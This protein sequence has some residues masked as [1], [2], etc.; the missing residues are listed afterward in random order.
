MKQTD[1]QFDP[2]DQARPGS[3]DQAGTDGWLSEA[4][5]D[6]ELALMGYATHL[7]KDRDR[8]NDLVQDVFLRLCRQP[9]G[10]LKG[11]VRQWL[12]RV[13]RNRA[14]DIMKKEGRM[15][16]LDDT[17]AEK[18]VS[19]DVDPIAKVELA[20]RYSDAMDLLGNLPERQQEVIR[21]KIEGG[22]SY[23][24]ISHATGL[25]V[26]NVG[27]LLSTGLKT[28]RERLTTTETEN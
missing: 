8:A 25:S 17:V 15:K 5:R 26:G 18:E 22:L 16:P 21:L 23:R 6:N 24:E 20:E 13:C 9:Q 10:K 7:V 11:R 12:F 14:L 27:Y 3:P 1:S 19:R 2:S 4:F 28:V